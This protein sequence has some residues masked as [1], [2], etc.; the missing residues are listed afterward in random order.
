MTLLQG[1]NPRSG[2]HAALL[3]GVTVLVL[4]VAPAVASAANRFASPTGSG[5]TCELGNPCSIET[6]INS[7][8]V[9]DDVTLL[10][11]L[12]PNPYSTSTALD[13]PAT[14]VTIHGAPGA[15]PVIETSDLNGFDISD[16]TLRDVVIEHTGNNGA[17]AFSNGGALIERVSSHASGIANGACVIGPGDVIRDSTCWFTG[18]DTPNDSNALKV[19]AGFSGG[20]TAT[21]RNV[22]AVS[23]G[24]SAGL[25]AAAFDGSSTVNATNLIAF[26][27][28]GP[29]VRTFQFPGFSGAHSIV[30]DHSN[31][32]SEQEAS[33]GD[34]TDAGTGDGN[35]AT[36]PV[37]IDATTGDFRQQATSTGTIDLG[38]ATGLLPGELDFEGQ[39]RN[40][41]AA[42]DIGADEFVPPVTP[43][44]PPPPPPAGGGGAGT[45][46]PTPLTSPPSAAP[47]KKCKKGFVKKKFKGKTKCVRKK[48]KRK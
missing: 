11:G 48:K 31:Y 45:V 34:I 42:P 33:A 13:P 30:L 19:F 25:W 20:T 41:G 1:R 12:P 29:D 46:T 16:G 9:N 28:T 39:A 35:Q 36:P 37:F 24:T 38:T 21:V 22:T 43:P 7:A 15:R 8:G 4:A 47:A 14:G 5:A 44:P 27:G 32:D 3:V 6:A 40:Q 17:G 26:S 2:A 23:S 10:G 18:V